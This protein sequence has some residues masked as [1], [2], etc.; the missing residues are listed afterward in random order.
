MA[1]L[2]RSYQALMTK[3]PWTVQIVTAG[4]N[5]FFLIS[6]S[7]IAAGLHWRCKRHFQRTTDTS[8]VAKRAQHTVV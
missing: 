6:I 3:Y 4:R 5:N 2:W 1:G 7:P 8:M